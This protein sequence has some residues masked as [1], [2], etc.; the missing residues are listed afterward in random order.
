MGCHSFISSSMQ[1]SIL[2]FYKAEEAGKESADDSHLKLQKRS[3]QTV[4]KIP[5][6]TLVMRSVLPIDH[7]R[8]SSSSSPIK[9]YDV[10]K[11]DKIKLILSSKKRSLVTTDE[12]AN[13]CLQRLRA[14]DAFYRDFCQTPPVATPKETIQA[15]VHDP[16]CFNNAR[17][18]GEIVHFGNVDKRMF[19]TMATDPDIVNHEL[20]HAINYFSVRFIYARQSGALDES[21][22]DVFAM[23]AKHQGARVRA[24]DEQADWGFARIVVQTGD[25]LAPLRSFSNPGSAYSGLTINGSPVFGGDN[26]VKYMRDYTDDLL[27]DDY[28]GVHK[29]SGIPNHGFYIAA[30]GLAGPVYEKGGIGE[31]WYKAAKKSGI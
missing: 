15:Y 30:K 11:P 23:I 21:I 20:G 26:Q 7:S 16:S 18:D 12:A 24:G 2:E 31:I 6:P 10:S 4:I 9:I 27:K 14:S 22:A 5:D 3:M 25:K 13:Q 17:W 28:G 1:K 19:S 8:V 29:Y